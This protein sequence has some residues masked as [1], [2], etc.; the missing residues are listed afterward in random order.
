MSAFDG[1]AVRR[2]GGDEGA[3]GRAGAW[4]TVTAADGAAVDALAAAGW[5]AESVSP[6]HR[7]RA[8]AAMRLL[9]LLEGA[10]IEAA[11]PALADAVLVRVARLRAIEGERGAAWRDGLHPEDA[12]AIDA[13][14]GAGFEPERVEEALRE[15]AR[16]HRRLLAALDVPTGGA[17]RSDLVERTLALVEAAGAGAAHDAPSP[18]RFR[19]FQFNDL[20]S[21]AAILLIGAAVVWPMLTGAI[22][23][24]RRLACQ[25]NMQAAGLGFGQYAGDYRDSLP[26]ATASRKG[27]PWWEVGRSPERSNS[28]NLYTLTRAGYTKVRD[29]ACAGNP[30]ACRAD[31]APGAMDWE[32]LG[33]VSFSYRIMFGRPSSSIHAAADG[34]LL[35]DRSPMYVEGRTVTIFP[36]RNSDNHLV[37]NSAGQAVGSGQNVLLRDGSVSWMASPVRANGDNLWLPRAV[38]QVLTRMGYPSEASRIE[39]TETPETDEDAFVGPGSVNRGGAAR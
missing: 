38:E 14:V 12:R 27:N 5:D 19:R 1:Q 24:G 8:R 35:T 39:G 17:G 32:C 33:Q 7:D 30:G 36:F 31:P 34:V 20:L 37:V 9:S 11:D 13:L 15:R 3:W 23:S 4:P 6:E 16:R 29:L 21:V 18:L 10:P 2:D 25:S 22:E 28:A 26:M